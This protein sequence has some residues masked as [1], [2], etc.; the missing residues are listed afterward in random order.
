M[1]KKVSPVG[2]TASEAA[3]LRASRSAAY[4]SEQAARAPF[5]EIAW[6]LIKYRMDKG[7]TQQELAEKVG[8]SYTQI[9][10]IES[11]RHKPNVET[12]LRIAHALDLKMLLGFEASTKE[13][14]SK[15]ELI[16]L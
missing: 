6:L 9:S 14:R 13:G 2:K 11:G 3:A 1:S 4:R 5:Q 7:L 15:R 8:T 16:T 12:L 10:R